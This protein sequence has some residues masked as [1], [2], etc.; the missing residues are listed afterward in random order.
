[1]ADRVRRTDEEWR[2]LLTAEQYRVMRE[3]G[4]ETPG[5]GKYYHH[6][7]KGV[8]VCSACGNE[9][10]SSDAKF[11]SGTGWPSFW[12]AA[13]ADCV[14]T[15]PDESGGR[16]RTEVHC[17][18]CG[19]HLGHLFSDGPDPTGMRYCVNS[20]SLGFR[21]DGAEE[22]QREDHAADSVTNGKRRGE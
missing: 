21:E 17:A 5:T 16:K 1:M 19:G 8:Y 6:A 10:F 11:E 14:E 12:A 22:E 20:V 13:A 18:R 3:K 2:E 4:T 15:E 7:G 9:L